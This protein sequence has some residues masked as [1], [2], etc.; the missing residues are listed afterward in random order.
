MT[1]PDW[2][3]KATVETPKDGPA[4][5]NAIRTVVKRLSRPHASGGDVIE[6]A[7]IVAEGADAIAIVKWILAHGGQPET[8]APGASRRGL[9]G[10]RL[11]AGGSAE[12]GTPR[13]Y[14]LPVD[15]MD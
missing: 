6:R 8:T 3:A 13:R 4:L 12:S 7:A 1:M 15:A 2:G 9:H 14:V 10:G 5:D 11:S